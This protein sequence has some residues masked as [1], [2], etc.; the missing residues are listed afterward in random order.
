[1]AC[2]AARGL[3]GLRSAHLARSAGPEGRQSSAS[4][5]LAGLPRRV[6]IFEEAI[7]GL[8]GDGVGVDGQ[9]G[10][11]SGGRGRVVSE[12]V[13][14]ETEMDARFEQR[15]RPRMAQRGHRG[16]LVDTA[17]PQGG[18]QGILHAV[19]RH[20]CGGGGHPQT[21]AARRWQ[22]P[23]G[24]AGGLPGLA[25][26]R[27]GLLGERHLAILGPFAV[28]HVDDH[29]GT[30]DSRDRPMRAFLE[31]QATGIDGAPA[32]AIARRPYPVEDRVH[33]LQAE[34]DRELV[35]LGGCTQVS[36]VHSRLSVCSEKT[37]MPHSA[38]GL[39]LRE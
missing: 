2:L 11:E 35:R 13:L 33:C 27:Q 12:V 16:A 38:M 32:S 3:G 20:G 31:L 5:R 34:A 1:M 14:H 36:V 37:L 25:A 30:I 10:R 24:R 39:A 15:G 8:G 18:A 6:E 17:S 19:A 22:Q 26:Q 23:H 21:A 9:V 29:A 28:A 4:A 7:D